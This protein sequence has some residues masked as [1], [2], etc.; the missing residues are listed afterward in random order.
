MFS[1]A[2]F[3]AAMRDRLFLS[4]AAG[5]F[6]RLRASISQRAI[7]TGLR[8]TDYLMPLMIQKAE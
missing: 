6:S 4:R 2:R 8:F 5:L 1:L 7:I 3:T